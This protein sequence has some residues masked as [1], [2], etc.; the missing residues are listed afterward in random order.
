MWA[1]TNLRYQLQGSCDVGVHSDRFT[2]AQRKDEPLTTFWN[3][4]LAAVTYLEAPGRPTTLGDIVKV[5][6]PPLHAVWTKDITPIVTTESQIQAMIYNFGVHLEHK[7]V[8][9]DVPSTTTAAFSA[10]APPTEEIR[11]LHK[12]NALLAAAN[13]SRNRYNNRDRGRNRPRDR[14]RDRHNDRN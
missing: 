12:R 8:E 1:V 4:V 6:T 9:I 14:D 10:V 5:K 7:S 13:A 11:L 3:D 2:L